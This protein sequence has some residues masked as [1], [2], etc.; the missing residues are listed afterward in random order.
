MDKNCHATAALVLAF[1]LLPF[2]TSAQ[3][4]T[5]GPHLRGVWAPEVGAGAAYQVETKGEGK[6][7]M[8]LAIVGTEIVD[9]KTGY[10]MEM[11]MKH[12]EHG[13]MV[14]KHLIVLADK[15]TEIKRMVMQMGDEPPIEMSLRMMMGQQA[16][17]TEPADIRN[18]AERLGTETLT[19]P[20]GTFICEH[21]RSKDKSSD[22]WLAEKVRPYGLIKMVSPDATM[23][24]IRV[25]SNAK[26]RIKGTPRKFEP[27][28]MMRPRPE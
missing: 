27:E 28:E 16:K 5:R 10:W 22:F 11:A 19:T 2:E 9:G 3:F 18:E 7:E 24:L 14:M 17:A 20:A 1:L 12:P 23:I 26:S 4:R 15:D 6:Q 8:E 21:W 25:I 13:Q